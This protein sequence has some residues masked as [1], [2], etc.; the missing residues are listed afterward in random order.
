MVLFE[1]LAICFYKILSVIPL[2][3]LYKISNGVASLICFFKFLPFRQQTRMNLYQAFPEKDERW[4]N[5]MESEYYHRVCEFGAELI[6]MFAPK[7]NKDLHLIIKNIEL[8]ESS[9]QKSDYVVCYAGHFLNY[10]I[11]THLPCMYPQFRLLCYYQSSQL[12]K[13][14]HFIKS[15]RAKF[16]AEL[17]PTSSPLKELLRIK[18][19]NNTHQK[20]IL[21]SLADLKPSKAKIHYSPFFHKR[22]GVRDGTEKVGKKIGASFL[23]AKIIRKELGSYE[24]EFIELKKNI[25][26]NDE[27]ITDCF[28]RELERNIQEQPDSWMLW[29][30]QRF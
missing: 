16:G 7:K 9:F 29:A 10:E 2:P 26:K 27:S 17:I 8:L 1:L 30:T 24:I 19:E 18:N 14:D 21:G 6:H 4:I 3:V 15:A 28:I 20:Y 25:L 22:I 12:K 11:L 23:Y 13:I 5:R